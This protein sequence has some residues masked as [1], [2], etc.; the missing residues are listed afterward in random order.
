M[1]DKLQFYAILWVPCCML[2]ILH[3]YR[4]RAVAK[5]LP[6]VAVEVDKPWTYPDPSPDLTFDIKS[7]E[8]PRFRAFRYSYRRH[9]IDVRKLDADSWVML[10]KDWPRY[11]HA[12][13]ARL[14]D[15]GDKVVRTLPQAREAAIE[16]CQDLGEFLSMRYPG[17][18]VIERSEKDTSGWH[19]KGSITKIAMP[20]LG[21]SYDLTKD[22]PLTVTGLIQPTDVNILLRGEEGY[23]QLVA[24]MIAIG[25]GQRI[26]DK[27]GRNLAD[28]H[29]EG[30]IP[31][32]Q[33][34][35][36]RPL[37]RFLSKLKV[38]SPIHR[39]TTGISI[40]DEFHWPT[41]TM[42]PEDDWDPKMRGPGV[43]TASYGKWEPPKP[44][45]DVSQV[46]FRQERQV[47]RRLPKSGAIVWMVHTYIEPMT[48]V[49][50]E[51]GVPGRLASLIR[52][53]DDVLAE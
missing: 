19:G 25:G 7:T 38:E 12:K 22:D 11:H 47:L 6:N 43:G 44:I 13:V 21:A 31:H 3:W 10:D 20:A 32:Y 52:S 1:L 39:N 15:R 28:L 24:M 42:G 49:A 34:Q 41:L 27:L 26:K 9:T 30:H 4:S 40:H 46:W 50:Q 5:S 8:P 51:P 37:D 16:L 36:Q 35:L 45:T 29:I 14:A 17:V 2:G 48:E 53:W 23:Y 18:Y 33:A